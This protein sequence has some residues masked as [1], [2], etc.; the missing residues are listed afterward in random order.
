MQLTHF[1]SAALLAAAAA[2]AAPAEE[3]TA[4]AKSMMAG[5][6]WTIQGFT[7]TCNRADTSCAYR[8]AV[9]TG[10]GSPTTCSY[11]VAGKPASHAQAVGVKCEFCPV[12]KVC[13]SALLDVRAPRASKSL[14]HQVFLAPKSLSHQVPP[15]HSSLFP[16]AGFGE[17]RC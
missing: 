4:S 1:L 7:R 3:A 15:V 5:G 17:R 6:R 12:A 8:F 10:A 11:N 14:S 2:V 9:N 16:L 13:S